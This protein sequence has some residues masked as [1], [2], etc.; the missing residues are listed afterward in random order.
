MHHSRS[1]NTKVTLL[2][3]AFYVVFVSHA[4]SVCI[5]SW[6]ISTE[7]VPPCTDF[8]LLSCFATSF[9]VVWHAG[10]LQ[11]TPFICQKQIQIQIEIQM[12]I[13]NCKYTNT[14]AQPALC[15]LNSLFSVPYFR[16][17]INPCW[18]IFVSW[19]ILFHN[20]F[21]SCLAHC[22]KVIPDLLLL[23]MIFFWNSFPKWSQTFILFPNRF[24]GDLSVWKTK[25]SQSPPFPIVSPPV[26]CHN[27]AESP[28]DPVILILAGDVEKNLQRQESWSDTE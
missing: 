21:L 7:I 15:C 6:C 10:R 12:Q 16:I 20:W 19:M 23:Y 24:L 14:F 26:P 28:Q 22:K 2:D 8:P 18:C 27:N 1:H 17:L 13:Q 3:T 11:N 5:P 25:Q 4:H 9:C